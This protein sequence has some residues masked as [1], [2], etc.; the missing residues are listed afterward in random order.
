VT[1]A[2]YLLKEF[3][4][5]VVVQARPGSH[6]SRTYLERLGGHEFAA[7]EQTPPQH[8]V[9]G[10]FEIIRASPPH[11]GLDLLGNVCIKGNSSSHGMMLSKQHHDVNDNASRYITYFHIINSASEI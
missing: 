7:R 5:I 10:L 8:V 2:F 6:L 3:A 1:W 11:L 4:Y 9:D